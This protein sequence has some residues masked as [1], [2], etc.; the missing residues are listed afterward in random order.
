MPTRIALVEDHALV[1]ESMQSLLDRR[2]DFTV[3]WTGDSI[4]ALL[5]RWPAPQ[6]VLLD[7]ELNGEIVTVK[8]AQRIMEYGAQ[9]VV[10]TGNTSPA[11]F[12]ELIYAGVHSVVAKSEP[13]GFLVDVIQR[14][15][16]GDEW[17][18]REVAAALVGSDLPTAIGLSS[19]ELRVL[20]LYASGL[21]IDAV[22]EQLNVSTNTVKGYLKRLRRKLSDAG[23]PAP[24]QR[25]L[26]AEARRQGILLD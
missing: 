25:D 23:R 11:S 20:Q 2:D 3:C 17:T 5:E 15:G 7:L 4:R 26:Y 1:R 13:F 8:D 12:R 14:A 9:I 24:T 18:T 21:K 10:V 22:A 19:Q 16:N 6:V